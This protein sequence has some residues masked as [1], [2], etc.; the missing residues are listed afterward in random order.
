MC[1]EAWYNPGKYLSD[2][3][4]AASKLPSTSQNQV[5]FL[6][7]YLPVSKLYIHLLATIWFGTR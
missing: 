7:P 6:L 5:N 4:D 3:S 1:L 2:E